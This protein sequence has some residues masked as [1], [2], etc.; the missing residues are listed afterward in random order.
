M[1]LMSIIM[2]YF[3][4][5]ALC[6]YSKSKKIEYFLIIWGIS[7]IVALIG[8]S[9][10]VVI[11]YEKVFYVDDGVGA[12]IDILQWAVPVFSHFTIII[13][14]I[15]T[16]GMGVDVWSKFK[17][18]ENLLSVFNP[19]IYQLKRLAIRNYFIKIFI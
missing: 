6:C 11:Y 9:V 2:G 4:F 12:I 16:K 18:I 19:N 13:E 3:K 8:I 7:H 15:S 17:E 5:C 10:V 14:S 1:K